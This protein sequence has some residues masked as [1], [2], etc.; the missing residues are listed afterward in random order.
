MYADAT[1]RAVNDLA[2]VGAGYTFQ[3]QS[4]YCVVFR[5][6]INGINL[7]SI[8]LIRF[9]ANDPIDAYQSFWER[10]GKFIPSCLINGCNFNYRIAYLITI[11]YIT[12]KNC[13][14]DHCLAHDT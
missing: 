12:S 7:G 3:G 6:H 9:H 5:Y 8:N 10:T 13:L 11:W 4:Q 2:W 1:G 14:F